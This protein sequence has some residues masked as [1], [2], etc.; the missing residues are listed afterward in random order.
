MFKK[1]K[2]GMVASLLAFTTVTSVVSAEEKP[3]DQPK[4]EQW[5]KEHAKLNKPNDQTTEDLSFFKR[6]STR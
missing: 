6:N 4:W 3:K 1:W 5:V 2:V